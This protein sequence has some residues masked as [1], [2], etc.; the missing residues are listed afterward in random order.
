MRSDVLAEII[1]PMNTQSK[2]HYWQL[3]FS[4]SNFEAHKL[5][6]LFLH[7]HITM[8]CFPKYFILSSSAVVFIAINFKS[9]YQMYKFPLM[10]IKK[11]Y[12][13]D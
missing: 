10:T 3:L 8:K 4:D 11:L 6:F 2:K 12:S 1:I 13:S 5:T 9:D 7:N